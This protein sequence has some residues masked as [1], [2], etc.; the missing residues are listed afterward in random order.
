MI[1][2]QWWSILTAVL[3]IYLIILALCCLSWARPGWQDRRGPAETPA[4][5]Q[6]RRERLDLLVQQERREQDR[7]ALRAQVA[8]LEALEQAAQDRQE[9]LDH[10][11]PLDRLVRP[12]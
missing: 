7:Q 6:A 10:P 2:F 9:V 1:I 11:V 8:A 3:S 4:D 5:R 12:E